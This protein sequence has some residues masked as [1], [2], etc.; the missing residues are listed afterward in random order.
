VQGDSCEGT[1][2][3][4]NG[5]SNA[6]RAR[7]ARACRE[8]AQRLCTAPPFHSRWEFCS[9]TTAVS[10]NNLTQRCTR[11]LSFPETPFIGKLA[12]IHVLFLAPRQLSCV[13]YRSDSLGGFRQATKRL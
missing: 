1:E 5:V 2:A 13:D 6:L 12:P 11:S 9:E 7:S 10:V 8:N 4:M 3:R